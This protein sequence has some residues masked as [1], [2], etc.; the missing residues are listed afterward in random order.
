M[1]ADT[2]EIDIIVRRNGRIYHKRHKTYRTAIAALNLVGVAKEIEYT[3]T[4][5]AR[6]LRRDIL[7]HE[8]EKRV[9]NPFAWSPGPTRAQFYQ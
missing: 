4:M 3:I 6:E 9:T 5:K 1:D 7:W 8:Q 2:T